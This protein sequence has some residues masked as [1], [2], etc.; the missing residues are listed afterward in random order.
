[1]DLREETQRLGIN[2]GTLVKVTLFKGSNFDLQ[3]PHLSC[4]R[5][6]K[7]SSWE[8]GEVVAGYLID[9]QGREA[10]ESYLLLHPS[11]SP[12]NGALTGYKVYSEAVLSLAPAEQSRRFVGSF[13]TTRLTTRSVTHHP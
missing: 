6:P 13:N 7:P 12:E 8:R 1:M 10:E 5:A 9:V 3:D 4:A 2:L 11:P